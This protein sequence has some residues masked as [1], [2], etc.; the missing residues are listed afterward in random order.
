VILL[1][2]KVH[3]TSPTPWWVTADDFYRQMAELQGR[4]VLTLDDY[5]PRN[6][7]HVVITFDGVYDNVLTFAAPV[8]RRFGYPFELFVSGEHLGQGND[9]DAV[10][11]RARFADLGQLRALQAL[12]GRLQW[13]GRSHLDLAGVADPAVLA[14]ELEV[15]SEL[16]AAFGEE[17]FRWFAYPHG[18]FSGA[19]RAAARQ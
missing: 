12:G 14:R 6:P 5:D 9:F 11:P 1:Y 17:H 15:P 18:G 2:H 7:D 19:A 3:P 8:L 16:R 10:E 4:R 13:H